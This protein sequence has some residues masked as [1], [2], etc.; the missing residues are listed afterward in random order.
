MCAYQQGDLTGALR[1]MPR[2]C[3]SEREVLQRLVSRPEAWEKAFFVI[4]PRLKKLYL[5][6]FQ[7]FLFDKVVELRLATIDRLVE[8]DLAWKHL[9]GACFLVENAATEAPRAESFEISASGPMFGSR[10]KQPAGAVLALEQDILAHEGLCPDDF[11]RGSGVRV[12]GER[13]PLRVP[14]EA[15]ACRMENNLLIV[16]FSLPRGSY[17]T[18]VV[19]EIT[20]AF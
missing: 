11:D 14:L 12:E 1:Q 20:K 18:S 10:M 7:S 19:R 4:H 6:A 9:N 16:E 13:R 17:A 5:S 2:H 3:R 15:A 8:G